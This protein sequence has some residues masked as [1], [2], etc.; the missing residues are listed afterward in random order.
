MSEIVHAKAGIVVLPHAHPALAP[1]SGAAPNQIEYATELIKS[2]A[3]YGSRS[4][5][6]IERE[7]QLA[8][9][10]SAW[11]EEQERAS[12]R[13]SG[14]PLPKYRRTE[15]SAPVAMSWNVDPE[16]RAQEKEFGAM[17]D[18]M[19]PVHMENVGGFLINTYGTMMNSKQI[20]RSRLYGI[21]Q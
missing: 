8:A 12:R 20:A 9:S 16:L 18:E 11:L 17:M 15:K 19:E 6:A 4:K 13:V 2:L 1:P 10:N 14:E 5:A 21:P 7:R 3:P